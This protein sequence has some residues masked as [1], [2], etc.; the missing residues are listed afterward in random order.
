MFEGTRQYFLMILGVFFI[1]FI[2]V[3]ICLGKIFKSAKLPAWKA[4]IP[5]YNRLILID[6][7][8]LKKSL[9]Y[10][11]LIPFYNLFIYK[12]IIEEL[13][14]AYKLNPKEAIYFILIP[15]Y[16]FPE[17]V[18]KNPKFMLHVYDETEEFIDNQNILFQKEEVK[19][20]PE[21]LP[22]KINIIPESYNQ[23][24]NMVEKQNTFN[25]DS[26]FTN[27]SLQ[28]DERHETIIE[29]KQE[30]KEERKPIMVDNSGQK[31]CPKCGTK[32]PQTATMCFLCGT[33]VG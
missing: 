1:V 20:V 2:T 31:V 17:L 14:K 21:E 9:F 33:K 26:V 11:T 6:L 7:L 4:Y 28:P 8:D 19:E 15:M 18:F 29:A 23:V 5:F 32:L 13:L 3:K 27:T 24:D 10:K 25:T 22:N 30:V 12:I 16:K